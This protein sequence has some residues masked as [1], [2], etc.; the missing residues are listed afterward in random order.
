MKFYTAD[1]YDLP[2][3]P[4]HRFPRA[5]Y[6]MLRERLLGDGV[7]RQTDLV[8]SPLASDEDVLRAHSANYVAQFEGGMLER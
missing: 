8:A 7:L 6:A 3:P 1:A 4:G 2:L 5:K